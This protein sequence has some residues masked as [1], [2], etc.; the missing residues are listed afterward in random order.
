M[1]YRRRDGVDSVILEALLK[2]QAMHVQL[3]MMHGRYVV[4]LSKKG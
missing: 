1:Q 4:H 3:P 2:L